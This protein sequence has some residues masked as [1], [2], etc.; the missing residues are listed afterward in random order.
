MAKAC[1]EEGRHPFTYG[2]RWLMENILWEILLR[3]F[4]KRDRKHSYHCRLLCVRVYSFTCG[5]ERK[6]DGG[7]EK[8]VV[9][10]RFGEDTEAVMKAFTKAYRNWILPMR[11]PWTM[12]SVRQFWHFPDAEARK[13]KLRSTIIFLLLKAASGR[14]ADRS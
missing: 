6:L 12:R 13:Q 1:Q 3:R 14:S 8:S 11:Q 4:P 2:L 7:A 10:E 9:R 5:T